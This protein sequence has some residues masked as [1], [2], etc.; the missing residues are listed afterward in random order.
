MLDFNYFHKSETRKERDLI[1]RVLATS[2]TL[3]PE[4]N[5]RNYYSSFSYIQELETRKGLT[6]FTVLYFGYSFEI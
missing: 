5:C 2:T 6:Y 1:A 4:R 3:R